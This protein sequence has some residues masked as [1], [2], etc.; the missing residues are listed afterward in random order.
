MK[1]ERE[2]N[3]EDQNLGKVVPL[4]AP[5]L[6]QPLLAPTASPTLQVSPSVPKR[7]QLQITERRTHNLQVISTFPRNLPLLV[8]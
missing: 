5:G 2:G 6:A 4:I 8:P 7:P 3:M 1:G